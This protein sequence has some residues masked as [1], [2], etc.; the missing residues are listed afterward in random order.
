MQSISVDEV[1]IPGRQKGEKFVCL[2]HNVLSASECADW[3]QFAESQGFRPALLLADGV[4][5]N[6]HRTNDR[7]LLFDQAKA[8]LL[9]ERLRHLL[10]PM[11]WTPTD[12]K[13]WHLIGLNERLS[14][15]RY[16]SSECY[17]RH[18]DVPYENE[19]AGIRSFVTCQVYLNQEF[20][21]GQTRFWQ[22]VGYK[23]HDTRQHLDIVPQTGS[24]L[25]FEHELTH[26]GC[27]V[28]DGTKYTLR[29]DALYSYRTCV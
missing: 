11:M 7:V 17:G 14:F 3:I 16:N 25:L 2:V 27:A 24:V 15:L 6:P 12:Y 23:T 20:R 22:E 28:E 10:P 1:I 29:V 21:G 13:N 5:K 19:A 18:V 26:E 4:T 8:A 9:T